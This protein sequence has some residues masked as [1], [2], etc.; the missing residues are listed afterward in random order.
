MRRLGWMIALFGMLGFTTIGVTAF[1]KR[2]DPVVNTD[3]HY[4]EALFYAYQQDYF[5]AI[6]RLDNELSQHYALDDP[7][8]DSFQ[9][10]RQAAEFNVGDFE[11]NYRLYQAAGR[12]ISRVVDAQQVA[13][14]VRNNAI[15]RLARLY[16]KKSDYLNAQHLLERIDGPVPDDIAE[17]M[18]LLRAQVSMHLNDPATAVKL[19]RP[20]RDSDQVLGYAQYNLG[21]AYILAENL[22]K[23]QA[24]LDQLG[25][26]KTNAPELIAL[27]D[28][29]NLTLGYKLL[30]D[31]QADA[32]RT[33]FDRVQLDGPFSNKA[34]LWAGWA[35]VAQQDFERALVPWTLLHKRDATDAAVQEALLALPYAYA[36]LASFG[37]AALLYGQAVV[38]FDTEIQRLDAAVA[39]V[40][41]GKLRQALLQDPAERHSS[42]IRNLR[43]LP[44]A[45]ET[46][47][48]LDLMASH[49]FQESVRNYRDLERLRLNLSQWLANISAYNDLI[50]VRRQYYEPLLPSIER[51]F[52][53]QNA[54]LES[55]ILRRD[56]VKQRLQ[57]AQR[58]R[59]IE[60]FATQNELS[61]R[62]QLDRLQYRLNRLPPQ[63]GLDQAKARLQR[64][65]GV[66]SW[67]VN[68]DYNQRLADAH[69]HLQQL[70]AELDALRVQ[71]QKVARLKR[72]AYQSYQ[73]YEIPLRRLTTRVQNTLTQITATMLQQ[74][75]YLE[76]RT[77]QA[78]DRR[79]R[80]LADYRVKARFALAESYDRAIN[81]QADDAEQAIRE[82]R[83]PRTDSN[84]VNDTPAASQ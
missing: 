51:D 71:Y 10:H 72:E 83:A 84:T 68:A 74:A 49:E 21:V 17:Q 73:G 31:G 55:V 53:I 23:G 38:E 14:E 54:L 76:K 56:T 39:G 52:K 2:Q 9:P 41:Q 61:W 46:R 64:L 11:L 47:Y 19:L 35:N 63:A 65:Q 78:L 28:K 44:D 79:R 50:Q 8:L 80:K 45:P 75:A 48:L 3:L 58:Q 42:F 1:A 66:L 13:P 15:Y 30:E 60:A 22:T 62:R 36:Q 5:N 77:I 6:I 25:L 20:L 34:L 81:K 82:Q 32:A 4:A 70:N 27:R 43:N 57:Q 18:A 37:R 26:L 7:Q 67:Q 16:V 24:Q 33:Y 59:D 40:L 12:A 69:K 29:A